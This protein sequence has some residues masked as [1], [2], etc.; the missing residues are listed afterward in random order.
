MSR[1]RTK[2]RCWKCERVLP[3]ADL[4]GKRG[5]PDSILEGICRDCRNAD[6]QRARH[7]QISGIT[8]FH[9]PRY[10][11]PFPYR[12]WAKK[13]DKAGGICPKC[14]EKARLTID[15]VVPLS[16]C[17]TLKIDNLEPL[18]RRCNIR[19]NNIQEQPEL[20]FPGINIIRKKRLA[21]PRVA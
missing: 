13:L 8:D 21:I 5:N 17:G 2:F 7:R 11:C 10:D 19:K 12:Q 14:K 20:E 6:A 16:K 15:H 4:Y 1:P 18:C 9:D 3:F